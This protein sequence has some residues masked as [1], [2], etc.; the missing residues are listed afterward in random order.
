MKQLLI[1]FIGLNC[2]TAKHPETPEENMYPLSNPLQTVTD[3]F[4]AT[5]RGDWNTLHQLFAPEVR[6]DYSSMNG[7]PAQILTPKAISSAWK[8]ILPGFEYTHHQIGN[9]NSKST[10]TTAK[11]FCYGT[12]QHYLSDPQGSVW[13]VVG[14]YDFELQLIH[15]EW[16]ITAMTFHYK[17]QTGNSSLIKKAQEHAKTH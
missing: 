17:F 14:S 2:L 11:V 10:E 8:S 3:L 1:L 4:I 9:F 15:K 16:R 6:L 5:D 13:T 12:A 7:Q